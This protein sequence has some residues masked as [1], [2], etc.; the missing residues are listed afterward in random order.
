MPVDLTKP[1]E[2]DSITLQELSMYRVVTEYR[3]S[4]GL[5]PVRL[6]KALSATAGRHVVDTRE[7][8]W[9]A[10]LVLPAGANNLHSWSDKYY[11]SDQRAPEVMWDA[12]A[13]LGTGYTSAGYEI[14]AAGYATTDAALAGWKASAAHNAV[15]ANTGVWSDVKFLAMGVGVETSPGAG[16]YAGRIFYVWFGEALDSSAPEIV[17]TS[18][19]DVFTG[20]VFGDIMHG[21]SGD[22]EIRGDRGDDEVRGGAGADRLSGDA[23]NDML[24][25]GDDDDRLYGGGG[26]DRLYGTSGN[27]RLLGAA[28][29]DRLVGGDGNDTL[30]G[31]VGRD[32]LTGEQGADVFVFLSLEESPVGAGCDVITD[33]ERGVDII[34]VTAIDA[35]AATKEIDSFTFIGSSKFTQ[36]AGQLRRTDTV[37]EG[38]VNGD[39]VADFQIALQADA[40]PKSG[41]FLY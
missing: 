12:P 41:D 16:D 37:V 29:D 17:G 39:G 34:D 20:T 40:T 27:D 30:I 32:I 3:S 31:G 6:S 11:Y 35:I 24:H 38:D 15:L 19:N 7:N 28:G 22:D 4:L 26:D 2:H 21:R 33:F 8:I 25:G 36:T 5:E 18:E 1:N 13:R 23:G 9:A 14:A 10:G